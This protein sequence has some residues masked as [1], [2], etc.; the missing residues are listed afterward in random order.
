MGLL[1]PA[2]QRQELSANPVALAAPNAEFCGDARGSFKSVFSVGVAC[3]PADTKI[4]PAADR[5]CEG[6]LDA[7]FSA[8]LPDRVG[9]VSHLQ[10]HG[11][12]QLCL[13]C[14]Q[15]H[16]LHCQMYLA[17][18]PC[19]LSQICL[20][21]M[22]VASWTWVWLSA[23]PST[24]YTPAWQLAAG[25]SAEKPSCCKTAAE[26]T[27]RSERSQSQGTS[28][29]PAQPVTDAKL[30]MAANHS[31]YMAGKQQNMQ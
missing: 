18:Y 30:Q 9:V 2:E 28:S 25:S 20:H 13:L 12:L 19:L 24:S 17:L 1:L 6:T 16:L 7:D 10:V 3:M 31:P 23:M 4:S 29:W 8:L 26:L 21:Q 27:G 5:G 14:L 15:L 11:R 22:Q